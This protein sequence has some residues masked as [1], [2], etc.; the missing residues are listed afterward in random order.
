M[1]KAAIGKGMG[2]A[3]TPEHS[4]GKRGKC[5]DGTSIDSEKAMGCCSGE[6]RK[7]MGILTDLVQCDSYV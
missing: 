6:D 2:R 5:Q 3:E 7:V 4:K 1:G